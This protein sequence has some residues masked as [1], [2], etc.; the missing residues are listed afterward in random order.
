[1]LKRAAIGAA[2]VLPAGT[3][4]VLLS[5]APAHAV[6]VCV[7]LGTNPLPGYPCPNPDPAGNQFDVNVFAAQ[8]C[9]GEPDGVG[10][11]GV[12]VG[13]CAAGV[14]GWTDLSG[15]ATAPQ[16]ELEVSAAGTSTGIS[17]NGNPE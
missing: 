5:A 14:D 15:G 7:G 11:T 4:P 8:P 16:G 6:G 17:S 1:L 10:Q 13:S 12:S 2:L 3:V 9:E